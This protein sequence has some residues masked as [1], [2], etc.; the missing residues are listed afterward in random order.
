MQCGGWRTSTGGGRCSSWLD[1]ENNVSHLFGVASKLINI[2]LTQDP[3]ICTR[4]RME[5]TLETNTFWGRKSRCFPNFCQ[6]KSK[7]YYIQRQCSLNTEQFWAGL[8]WYTNE[9]TVFTEHWTILGGSQDWRSFTSWSAVPSW[10]GGHLNP[11]C[12][13]NWWSVTQLVTQHN[14]WNTIEPILPQKLVKRNTSWT[15]RKLVKGNTTRMSP[16]C[17]HWS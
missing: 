13:E 9:W 3:R 8:R 6:T 4:S 15:P 16:F 1:Y 14:T 10:G 5:L 2:K 11:D 12:H 7:W 17:C